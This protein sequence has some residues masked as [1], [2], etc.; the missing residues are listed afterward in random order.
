MSRIGSGLKGSP[1]RGPFSGGFERRFSCYFYPLHVF[2]VTGSVP[3][4]RADRRA[5]LSLEFQR[6][7]VDGVRFN[8][9]SVVLPV[10]ADTDQCIIFFAVLVRD[11]PGDFQL[12]ALV[13]CEVFREYSGLMD[14][15]CGV[16]PVFLVKR[17]VEISV[18]DQVLCLKQTGGK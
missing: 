10:A 12:Q 14:S 8:R 13:P 2:P 4:P 6:E 16:E 1:D 11:V 7:A 17:F 5:D 3:F 9:K 15:R 18:F